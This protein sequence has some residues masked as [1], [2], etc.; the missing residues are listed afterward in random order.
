MTCISGILVYIFVLLDSVYV[1]RRVLIV[2]E[3][4]DG[5]GVCAGNVWS[6]SRHERRVRALVRLICV[7]KRVLFPAARFSLLRSVLVQRSHTRGVV[8]ILIVYRGVCRSPVPHEVDVAF[9]V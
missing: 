3:Y 1:S 7:L 5:V 8:L 2:W 6:C 4:V 9:G